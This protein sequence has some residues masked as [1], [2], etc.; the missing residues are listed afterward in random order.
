LYDVGHRSIPPLFKIQYFII[1]FYGY[2]GDPPSKIVLDTNAVVAICPVFVPGEAVAAVTVP[3]RTILFV[4]PDT[5][6]P[7][8]ILV[9]DP[10]TPAVPML[11]VLVTAFVVA[12][13][14]RSNVCAPVDLPTVMVPVCVVP[15]II[16]VPVVCDV[17]I[18]IAPVVVDI[19]TAAENV[20]AAENV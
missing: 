4:A 8:F 17:P 12:P 2:H 5:L 20:C 7:I 13:E 15:P 16:V 11:T 10:E 18:F 6:D 3:D 1:T 14:A 19:V 9:V